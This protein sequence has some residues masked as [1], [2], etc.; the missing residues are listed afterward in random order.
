MWVQVPPAILSWCIGAMLERA[1]DL[2]IDRIWVDALN[3]R[4]RVWP[5]VAELLRMSFPDL[6]QEYRQ[7]LFDESARA[8]Y[9]AEI[10]RRVDRAARR[11]ALSGR[12][13]ACM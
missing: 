2:H 10:H 8:A 4:P 3:P 9:L 1:A 13:A 11:L 5:A 12:V 6:L 7:I